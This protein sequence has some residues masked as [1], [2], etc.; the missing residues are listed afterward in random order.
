MAC[1]LDQLTGVSLPQGYYL[2]KCLGEDDEGALYLTSCGRPA[3]PAEERAAQPAVLKLVAGH[4]AAPGQLAAW[5]RLSSLS[6]P[7]LLSLLDCG[8]AGPIGPAGGHF[9]YAVFEHPDDYLASALEGGPLSESDARDVLAAVE[10]GLRFLHAHGLAQTS[11][12]PKHIVAVGDRIKLSSDTVKPLGPAATEAVDWKACGALRDRLL[13]G[14]ENTPECTR[15]APLPGPRGD[16]PPVEGRALGP[17]E[18]RRGLPVWGY[19]A[20]AVMLVFLLLTAVR[21]KPAP[22]VP[23]PQPAPYVPAQAP[24]PAVRKVLPPSHPA[25]PANWRVVAYTYMRRKD[26]D[27]KVEQINAKFPGFVPEV[28]SPKGGG[29]PPYLVALGGRMTRVRA[30]TLQRQ[31]LAKGLP[32]GT[33]VQ[34]FSN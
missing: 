19:A 33:Y 22:A 17:P 28:F 9:L 21:R 15:V 11:V 30:Q 32:Q 6:H 4:S 26:A 31:A 20:L 2:E 24:V 25:D 27:H 10:T 5:E 23:P 34:N 29:Q 16:P 7:N 1:A 3:E 13:G 8:R 12:D 18:P 14:L